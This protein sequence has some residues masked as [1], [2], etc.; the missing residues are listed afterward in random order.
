MTPH[1]VY[2]E[3]SGFLLT[4]RTYGTW[5]PGDRRGWTKTGKGH[6]LPNANLESYVKRIMNYPPRR[7]NSRH[8]QV[9]C[10]TIQAYSLFKGWK[11]N[12]V[13]CQS[14]HV[15]VALRASGDPKKTIGMLKIRCTRELRKGGLVGP[16][17]AK[18]GNVAFLRTS[19]AYR[20]AVLYVV[21][22][23]LAWLVD[24]TPLTEILL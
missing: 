11:C 9:V 24:E 6:Q 10:Q 3:P 5:L 1:I 8:R 7:L 23:E 20:N 22:H 19:R 13:T 4:W 21:N 17:W 18:R 16:V 14:N 12:A 15:H 2:H